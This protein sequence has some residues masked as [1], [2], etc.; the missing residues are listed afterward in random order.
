MVVPR[1]PA[2]R[3]MELDTAADALPKPVVDD[4]RRD[5]RLSGTAAGHPAFRSTATSST[6]NANRCLDL[7]CKR[8]FIAGLQAPMISV[9]HFMDREGQVLS[10]VSPRR[11]FCTACHVPQMPTMRT[12]GREQRFRTSTRLLAQAKPGAAMMR[13]GATHQ[14]PDPSL[15]GTG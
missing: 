5:A 10:D 12:A 8:E 15:A 11:Y 1:L 13:N 7:P 6:L 3:W 2:R 4:I 9:T 14:R